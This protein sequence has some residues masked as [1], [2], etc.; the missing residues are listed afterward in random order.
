MSSNEMFYREDGKKR[1]A[2][3]HEPILNNPKA[4]EA[5]RRAAVEKAVRGGMDRETATKLF[6]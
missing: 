4:E 1:D 2:K 3:L 5:G 6:G